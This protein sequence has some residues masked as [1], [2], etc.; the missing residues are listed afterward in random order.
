MEASW[1]ELEGSNGERS[2]PPVFPGI[3]DDGNGVGSASIKLEEGIPDGR[4]CC[5]TL[6]CSENIEIVGIPDSGCCET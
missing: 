6:G 5:E 2:K 4:G 3:T 1:L